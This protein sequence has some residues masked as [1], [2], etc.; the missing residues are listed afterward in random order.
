MKLSSISSHSSS[1][2]SVKSSLSEFWLPWKSTDI[3]TTKL[4]WIARLF[5]VHLAFISLHGLAWYCYTCTCNLQDCEKFLL[6]SCHLCNHVDIFLH[7]PPN[8]RGFRCKPS[9][10]AGL[11]LLSWQSML[12]MTVINAIKAPKQKKTLT[13]FH[14]IRG[15]GIC[16]LH[17]LINIHW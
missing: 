17:P 9:G 4:R 15:Q 6:L 14:V 13:S 7:T 12:L 3:K 2:E 11:V 5:K 8:S 1:N 16:T 10:L